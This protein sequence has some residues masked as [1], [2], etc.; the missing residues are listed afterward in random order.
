[1]TRDELDDILE[2]MNEA[3]AT[4]GEPGGG[5]G[6]ITVE[7]GWWVAHLSG[8]RATC[9]ALH[10]GLRYRDVQ[11]HVGSSLE[12]QV[13]SRDDAG[14]RGAPYRDLTLRPIDAGSS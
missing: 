2:R 10:D 6:L 11:V 9:S 4:L 5:P 7:S 1:M 12:T 3:C 8:V 14:E 13:L